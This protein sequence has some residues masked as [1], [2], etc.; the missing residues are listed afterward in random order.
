MNLEYVQKGDGK[1]RDWLGRYREEIDGEPPPRERLDHYCEAIFKD[2]GK[3]RHIFWATDQGRQVGFAIALLQPAI[4]DVNAHNGLIAEF[5]IYP[6]Y[7]R[8]GFGGRL[9]GSLIEFLKSHGANEVYATVMAGNVRGL[10]F[11]Q[12]CGFQ[13]ARYSLVHRPGAPQ[14]E[15]EEDEDREF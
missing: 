15:D 14:E 5:Y 7:R 9:A 11:L 12:T 2:Q 3:T 4:A 6:E 13:I 10:R 1:F 8:E